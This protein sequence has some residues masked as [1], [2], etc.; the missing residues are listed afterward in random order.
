M[1]QLITL[2]D[3]SPEHFEALYDQDADINGNVEGYNGQ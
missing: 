1:N 2:G 3:L